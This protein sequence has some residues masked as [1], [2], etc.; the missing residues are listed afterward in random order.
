MRV[1]STNLARPV[2]IRWKGR[3]QET[4][5]YKKPQPGG[6][7]LERDGVKG[8]TIGNPEVHGGQF[9]AC[10]LFPVDTYPYWKDRYPHLDWDYGMFGENLSMEGLIEADLVM[11]AVYRLGETRL[12][13]T[14][15][16]EPCYKLGIRFGDQGIIERFVAHARPGVYVEVLEE[17]LVSPGM[18]A[19]QESVP[20]DGLK[21]GDYFK[22]LFNPVKNPEHLQKALDLPF[23]ND[24]T[25]NKLL[26]WHQ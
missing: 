9:K 8:D 24:K 4:G 3:D 10:Y 20:E 15:P 12:R 1:V 11:G 6:I 23:L 18:V 14:I 7:P 26:R 2:R 16:R 5:I 25:R 21:V 19:E 22:L 17:G 13:L